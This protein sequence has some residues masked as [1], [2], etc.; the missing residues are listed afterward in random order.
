[1]G[2]AQK[3]CGLDGLVVEGGEVAAVRGRRHLRDNLVHIHA[4]GALQHGRGGQA[5]AVVVCLGRFERLR[6]NV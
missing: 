2:A 3:G 5:Q 4:D 1:M 6:E